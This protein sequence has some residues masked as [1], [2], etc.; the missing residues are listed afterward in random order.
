MKSSFP[1]G[2][3][4]AVHHPADSVA[5]GSESATHVQQVVTEPG[6]SLADD[7]R[8]PDLHVVLEVVDLVVHRV[9]QVE[10]ALRDVVDEAVEDHARAAFVA[11]RSAGRVHI[12]RVVG[13]L[14]GGRLADGEHELASQ[15]D[16]DLLVEDPV[17]LGHRDRHEHDAEDVVALAFDRGPWL[18][19][20]LRRL[21]Q[22]LDRTR[23]ECLSEL[24]LELGFVRIDEVDPLAHALEARGRGRLASAC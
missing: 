20:V 3:D 17:L 7:G 1:S 8:G 10:V 23:M 6:D 11:V 18:V 4:A 2:A 15:D 24:P 16:V 9:D 19:P 13:L 22:P 21:E 12:A 5:R 14:A